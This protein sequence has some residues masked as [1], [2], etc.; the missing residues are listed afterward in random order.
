MLKHDKLITVANMARHQKAKPACSVFGWT[1][2]NLVPH[3]DTKEEEDD[4]DRHLTN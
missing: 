1:Q 2:V 4:D 3:D